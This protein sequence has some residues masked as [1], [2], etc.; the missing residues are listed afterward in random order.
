MLGSQCRH[1]KKRAG[2]ETGNKQKMAGREQGRVCEHLFKYLDLLTSWKK[3]ICGV[4]VSKLPML[5]FRRVS[6]CLTLKLDSDHRKP[7]D[8]RKCLTNRRVSWELVYQNE[9]FKTMLTNSTTPSLLSPHAVFTQLFLT[10]C[11]HYLGA[12]NGLKHSIHAQLSDSSIK[13][14]LTRVSWQ[15]CLCYTFD[16][17]PL[18]H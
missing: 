14:A 9:V 17:V 11:P 7:N 2:S 3:N 4:N 16:I 12:W 10:S 1:S 15:H 13:A 5:W 18:P 8:W 6:Q